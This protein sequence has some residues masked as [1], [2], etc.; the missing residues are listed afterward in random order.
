MLMFAQLVMTALQDPLLRQCLNQ[1]KAAS[2]NAQTSVQC[3]GQD[4]MDAGYASS[5]TACCDMCR[6]HASC[7]A[8]TYNTGVDKH[9]WLK[10]GC[11]DRRTGDSR[12]TSGVNTAPPPG[13][14]SGW[15]NQ[16]DGNNPFKIVPS[17]T[18]SNNYFL[19]L[20]DWGKSGGP[21]ECQSEVARM[22]KTYVRDQASAGK[23]LLFVAVVGD[24]FYWTGAN[25][26]SAW[27]QQWADVYSTTTPG[28]PFYNVPFLAVM[29]NHDYG[30]TDPTAACPGQG[31]F[32][33][34]GGQ[35][36]GS[37]QFNADKNPSRPSFTSYF[38]LPDYNYHYEIPEVGLELIAVDQNAVDVGGLGGDASGHRNVFK[39]CGGEGSVAGFLNLVKDSG[40]DLLRERAARGTASTVVIIQHYPSEGARLKS[41]FEGALGR[42]ASVL[43]A[44]GHTHQQACLGS[45]AAGQC[46]VILTGGG[47]GC[48]ASDLAH[49]HA[50]FTAVHLTD[51]GAFT[52]DLTSSAVR[53]ASGQCSW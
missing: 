23:K 30:D 32:A 52:S 3:Y 6:S 11:S 8:W 21:G 26:E 50:G 51:D 47:G 43:S 33:T 36:Y 17:S 9:C 45:N 42:Q 7:N 27:R 22:M 4:V 34:V 44:F 53:L 19:I 40:E 25:T 31:N 37:H 24:N 18:R 38:H 5:S 13:P 15:V 10:T 16:Y 28:E 14:P 29:G 41:L 20:G 49:N 46:D 12:Y 1:T 39:I 2:C 35:K 48:C